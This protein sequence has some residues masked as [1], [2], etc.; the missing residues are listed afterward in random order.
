V[1]NSQQEFTELKWLYRIYAL[2]PNL[3]GW[4]Q[5]QMP[6][7]HVFSMG[8]NGFA[9]PHLY[10]FHRRNGDG[11]NQV[12]LALEVNRVAKRTKQVPWTENRDAAVA[13]IDARCMENARS[14]TRGINEPSCKYDDPKGKATQEAAE[15]GLAMRKQAGCHQRE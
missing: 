4:Q 7:P 10:G 2:E 14:S 6:S 15:H 8:D 12:A 9:S 1:A 13:K 5:L 3:T 11:N